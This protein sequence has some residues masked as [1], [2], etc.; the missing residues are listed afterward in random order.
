VL[1]SLRETA[2]T[3]V[4]KPSMLGFQGKQLTRTPE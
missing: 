2:D 4:P 3:R 1:D